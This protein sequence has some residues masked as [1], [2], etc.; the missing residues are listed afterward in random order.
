MVLGSTPTVSLAAATSPNRGGKKIERSQ[1]GP[2]QPQ[3]V[4][5]DYIRIRFLVLAGKSVD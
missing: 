3:S 2:I 4:T 5:F 1:L